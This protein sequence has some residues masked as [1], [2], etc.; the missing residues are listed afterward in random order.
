MASTERPHRIIIPRPAGWRDAPRAEFALDPASRFVFQFAAAE[1]G[2]WC[3]AARR[4]SEG[5]RRF[6]LGRF[7]VAMALS[8]MRAASVGVIWEALSARTSQLF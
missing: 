2:R 8:T 1:K 5:V 4:R 7:V 6:A 3:A